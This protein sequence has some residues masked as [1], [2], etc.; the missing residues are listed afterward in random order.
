MSEENKL[1]TDMSK[2]E[3]AQ[4]W[5]KEE[6]VTYLTE[7]GF[8]EDITAKFLTQGIV[9]SDLPLIDKDDLKDM[10]IG[11]GAR[12]RLLRLLADFK[13]SSMV[14]KQSKVLWEGTEWHATP[15]WPIF[16][17]HYTLTQT[18]LTLRK[19]RFC[20]ETQDRIDLSVMTNIDLF[21]ECCFATVKIASTDSTSPYIEIR[22]AREA[23][24]DV[25][26]QIRDAWEIDQQTMANARFGT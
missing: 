2:F 6:V 26:K 8:P 11:V 20:G 10:N 25:Y 9:G 19:G 1:Q 15:C 14:A 17:Q 23:G 3:A 5:T 18:A 21:E 7:N 16:K 4:S 13:Y 12:V 22:A 24:N